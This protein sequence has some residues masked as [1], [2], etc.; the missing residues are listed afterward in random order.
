MGLI[1]LF[2]IAVGLSMDAFAVSV[3]KGLAMPK[4]TFKKAAIVGLW[5]GG[6]QALMPAIG[7]ILGAQFQEAIASID[8]WIAFVLLALIGGNMIH[9]AL[10]NDEEEAD[11]SLDVKTMFL[12][13]VATSIDALAIGITFAFLKVNIIPAVCFIGIVTFIISFAGVKIGNVFGARYKNKAEIV[14]GV[15]LILLGLKILL[16]HLGFLG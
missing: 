13:A 16:E 15:I 4:C 5:F 7:Y 11:A 9:E 2:L 8:H 12:L 1:E 14:G 6:F 10:D 3:C